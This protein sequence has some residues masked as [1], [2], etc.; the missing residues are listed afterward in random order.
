[1]EEREHLSRMTEPML[2]GENRTFVL[3]NQEKE[4]LHT[5]GDL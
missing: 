1:M 5:H 2:E 4:K 3:V